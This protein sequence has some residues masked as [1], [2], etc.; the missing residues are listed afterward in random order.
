M[1][2]GL[3]EQVQGI[4]PQGVAELDLAAIQPQLLGAQ[5]LIELLQAGAQF[6]V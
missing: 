3:A 4:A 6:G 5:Q 1:K 2:C